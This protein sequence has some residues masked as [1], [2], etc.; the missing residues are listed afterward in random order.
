MRPYQ[1][2]QER[3][4]GS[5]VNSGPSSVDSVVG[6]LAEHEAEAKAEENEGE[7]HRVEEGPGP[8]KSDRAANEGTGLDVGVSCASWWCM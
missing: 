6:R 5:G 8:G 7:E 4:D 2:R 3:L 1:G